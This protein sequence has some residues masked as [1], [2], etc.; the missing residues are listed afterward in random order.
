MSPPKLL[1]AGYPQEKFPRVY[2]LVF[3]D[4]D[5]V[6]KDSVGVKTDAFVQLFRPY[7]VEISERVRA[8]HE[9]NGGMSRFEKLPLYLEWADEPVTQEKIDE[10][11]RCF[12]Q[13]VFRGVIDAPWVPGVEAFLRRN[14]RHQEFVL[15]TATPQGEIGEILEA[16]DLRGCFAEVFGAPISKKEAIR[17]SL[18]ARRLDASQCLMIGDAK[19]D[20]EAAL[21]NN[22]PFLLRRH[23]S[24]QR[25]FENY[26]GNSVEDF[27]DL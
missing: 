9:A 4:F 16:I 18:E 15:V 24:N 19:A 20:L 26:T 22:V 17:V 3:W 5:G 2:K 13:L 8:H 12:S 27:L 11:C 6:I 14:P 21:A 10:C 23:G 7:G 25:V 1:L